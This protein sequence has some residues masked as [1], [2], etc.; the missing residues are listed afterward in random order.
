VDFLHS[1]NLVVSQA[2]LPNYM[3]N[4]GMDFAYKLDRTTVM[5]GAPSIQ[6][7]S[8]SP[9]STGASSSALATTD[10]L[11]PVVAEVSSLP[12]SAD[13]CG[14]AVPGVYCAI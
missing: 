12:S 10:S 2:R 5:V 13:A 3:Y 11:A 7:I 1:A 4:S 9:A 14:S 6:A 8:T